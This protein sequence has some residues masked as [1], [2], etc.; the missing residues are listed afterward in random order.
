[1]RQLPEEDRCMQ[2][3]LHRPLALTSVAIIWV[4]AIREGLSLS[5][6]AAASIPPLSSVSTPVAPFTILLFSSFFMIDLLWLSRPVK[7]L[8]NLSNPSGRG[9]WWPFLSRA[10]LSCH[11]L[12][13]GNWVNDDW[14]HT[15]NQQEGTDTQREGER[16]KLWELWQ[17][18][19]WRLHT[20]Q[21]RVIATSSAESLIIF[22]KKQ[23]GTSFH[24][25]C[26]RFSQH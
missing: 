3:P 5:T 7:R 22:K 11:P 18:W 15:R 21:S 16:E 1:M 19:V 2:I 14:Q 25:F 10:R 6:A 8:R 12:L 9:C 23:G 24:H 26:K 20:S 17:Q 13:E 4:G